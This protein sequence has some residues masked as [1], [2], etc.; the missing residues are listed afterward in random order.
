MESSISDGLSMD[1]SF[2]GQEISAKS[3]S[4]VAEHNFAFNC[5]NHMSNN[6]KWLSAG[7]IL[8]KNKKIAD[9]E[10]LVDY[11]LVSSITL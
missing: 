8:I 9:I 5:V 2:L 10:F 11:F 4:S 3:I 6:Q 1:V 7:M